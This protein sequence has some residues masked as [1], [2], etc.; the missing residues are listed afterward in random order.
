V[1]REY[2]GRPELTRE[3]FGTRVVNQKTERSYRTGDFVRW[4]DNGALEYMGRR[5]HQVKVRGFRIELGEIENVLREHPSVKDAAVAARKESGAEARLVAYVVPRDGMAAAE[6]ELL[7]LMKQRLPAY[8]V[9]S[10]IVPLD[11]LP[12]TPNGKVDRKALPVPR[13][14]VHFSTEYVAP[15][16]KTESQVAGIWAA[17]LGR[18]RL[19][20]DDNFFEIGGY[21]LLAA[22]AA[23]LSQERMDP[24]FLV[25]DLFDHQTI[26]TLAAELD[27]RSS[28]TGVRS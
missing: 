19:G 8:M 25:R 6:S 20:V 18:D 24:G 4:L 15:R 12:L 11:A 17:V 26:A 21:S 28:L 9:P 7:D 3:K 2:W 1:A 5:D 13:R 16:T 14:S 23:A 27:Q 10:F 22:Q